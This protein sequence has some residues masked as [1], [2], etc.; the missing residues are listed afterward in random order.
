MDISRMRRRAACVVTHTTKACL[1]RVCA[2]VLVLAFGLSSYLAIGQSSP[3]SSGSVGARDGIHITG[4]RPVRDGLELTIRSF[5]DFTNRLEIFACEE[6][7]LFRWVV[8][9]TGLVAEG[10]GDLRWVDTNRTRADGV[11]YLVGNADVDSDGDGLADAREHFVHGTSP[12]RIDSDGDGYTDRDELDVLGT[13]PL[14]AGSGPGRILGT[15]TYAGRQ[16]GVIVVLA[17]DADDAGWASGC[18][19]TLM[20]PG[21][22]VVRGLTVPTPQRVKVYRDMNGNGHRDSW[23]AFGLSQ[24]CEVGAGGVVTGVAVSLTDPDADDD[25]LPDWWEMAFLGDLAQSGG[26]DPDRD[27]WPNEKEYQLGARPKTSWTSDDDDV[28]GL[29]VLTPM[30]RR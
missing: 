4:I 6:F 14:D 9:A 20:Q 22:Y 27:G 16:P 18:R 26:D 25:G 8:V 21:E 24:P 3:A 2:F 13:D 29:R 28:I 19:A 5:T 17:V 11:Y 10:V 30:S 15:V 12:T 1:V 23:E 7:S